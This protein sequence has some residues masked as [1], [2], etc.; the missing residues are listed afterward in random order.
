MDAAGAQWANTSYEA[1]C[2]FQ[3]GPNVHDFYLLGPN[4]HELSILIG[5]AIFLPL[6]IMI[7][8]IN[9]DNNSINVIQGLL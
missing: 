3:L 2:W 1:C 5:I 9:N 4:E 8:I 7:I 6:V